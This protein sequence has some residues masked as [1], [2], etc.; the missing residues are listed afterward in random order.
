MIQ[1]QNCSKAFGAEDVFHHLNLTINPHNKIGLIGP[2]GCGKTTLIQII[3]GIQ[4]P[5][6]G[7]VK[8]TQPG[9]KPAYL[10]QQVSAP[11]EQ[12]ITDYLGLP[13]SQLEAAYR[14]L[15][16]LSINILTQP[17][18]YQQLLEN[19]EISEQMLQR[20]RPMQV[21][22]DLENISLDQP[23]MHLS[24][25]QKTRLT[26]MKIALD[27]PDL[28]LLDEPTNHLDETG[29]DWLIEWIRQS[30]AS[31]L[32]VSHD[33]DF[34]DQ[35]AHSIWY[36]DK[37]KQEI[38]Q[39]E[40]NYSNFKAYQQNQKEKLGK[41]YE[42]QCD[43]IHQLQQAVKTARAQ[44]V[45]KKGGKGDSGDKFAK[46]FF[47][48]RT[49]HMMKKAINLEKRLDDLQENLEAPN[50][51]EWL[52]SIRF[53]E[54]ERGGDRVLETQQIEFGYGDH[55]VVHSEGLQVRYGDRI[56]LSGK[57]GSGKTTILQTLA[58]NLP[59]VTGMI[60]SGYGIQRG[61]LTQ[62]Q[63][64][65]P[66]MLHAVSYL[67]SLKPSDET[68]VRNFLARYL[69]TH[70]KVHQPMDTL[71]NGEK[72][73]LALAGLVYRG[74]NLLFLDEPLNHLDI[75][76]REQ[77]QAALQQ[78]SGTI[79]VVEHDPYFIRTFPTLHWHI[80]NGSIQISPR[81]S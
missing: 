52:L 35:V 65:L 64:D 42:M 11:L 13:I 70:D 75:P 66:L 34:I 8:I 54:T 6:Q 7:S 28:I 3:A 48:D 62:E 20:I 79:L 69:F 57:N 43:E 77:M 23:F 36:M 46:G 12:S 73:R 58:G 5:D 68:V 49:T 44:T 39:F 17:G 15:E 14:Q 10:P 61:Y 45:K 80:E 16:D 32:I 38:I 51:K 37:E 67:Q 78:F 72:K 60:R 26:L 19:I 22:L 31:M 24:S 55:I 56:V 47:N 81:K 53:N 2:N 59:P 1:I 4:K 41:A 27:P 25:G 74:C 21:A 33:R 30:D 9:L 18:A 29:R 76:A 63:N 50:D 40:G 71:S